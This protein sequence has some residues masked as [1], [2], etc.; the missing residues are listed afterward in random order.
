MIDIADI[1]N[2]LEQLHRLWVPGGKYFELAKEYRNID[3]IS[4]IL[5]SQNIKKRIL[6]EFGS[7]EVLDD[8]SLRTHYDGKI[9]HAPLGR[10]LHVPATNVFLGA[11]DSVIMG[12]VTK[13]QNLVKLSIKCHPVLELFVDSLKKLKHPISD[14]VEFKIWQGGD[15]KVESEIF[16]TI[17]AVLFWGGE[18]A[19]QSL[20][21][22]LPIHV[23]FIEHGPKISFQVITKEGLDFSDLSKMGLDIFQY[24]QQA[25]ANAQNIF[26]QRGV[27]INQIVRMI[28]ETP[29][30]RPQL[31][32]DEAVDNLKEAQ[33]AEY[34]A[35]AKN[36][37]FED[38][39][40]GRFIEGRALSLEPTSLNGSVKIKTF[41]TLA[42]LAE[43]LRP[44]R[45]Y[46]QSCGVACAPWE[47]KE[48]RLRLSQVG[49]NRFTQ[50]GEMLKGIEGSPHDG[51]FSLVSLTKVVCDESFELAINKGDYT[52]T[53]EADFKSLNYSQLE[54]KKGLIFASGGTTGDAKHIF[55]TPAEFDFIARKLAESYAL[56]T[57]DV[58]A[59]LFMAGNM[60]SSFSAIQQALNYLSV[61]QLP[62]GA[63]IDPKTFKDLVQRFKVNCV[64]GLPSLLVDL[65]SQSKGLKI[66]KVFYAGEML[67]Q[68]LKN[69]L[70]LNWNVDSFCSAGYASVDVGPIGYQDPAGEVGEHILFDHLVDLEI[71]NS[72]AFVTSKVREACPV[73][74]YPTGDRI[75]ILSRDK[76]KIRFKLLGRADQKVHI[77]STRFDLSEIE[78][79]LK[80]NCQYQEQFQVILKNNERPFR[81]KLEIKT[82]QFITPD[83]FLAGLHDLADVK[84]TRDIEYISEH[85]E[86]SVGNFLRNSKTGKIPKLL[87]LRAH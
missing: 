71:I 11:I 40:Q 62:M 31:E 84:A 20:K 57:G 54:D 27:E 26:I 23:K 61:L 16:K 66:D 39:P 43:A 52:P 64:F 32:S 75:E 49:V 30:T 77:W 86:F 38:G 2:G 29:Y 79:L 72:E 76:G 60:W 46:M 42:E 53:K 48:L 6:A 4:A 33:L 22:R 65:S 8:F 28:K 18:S 14:M 5:D 41:E 24:D 70:I 51:E 80:H 47:R 81:E 45:Y 56:S 67:T 44:F 17:D 19:A 12:L 3:Q 10:V 1:L 36:I 83:D 58:V 63:E 34:E 87:D 13:N 69:E 37:F 68:A 82:Q 21:S 78:N 15:V 35:F 50:L 55:Y 25:C 59:N 7:L 74:K 9:Y 85:L 73:I